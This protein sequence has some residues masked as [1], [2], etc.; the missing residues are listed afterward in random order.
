MAF[1]SVERDVVAQNPG[2][3]YSSLLESAYKE[4]AKRLE[5]QIDDEEAKAFG[6]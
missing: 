5:V 2:V 6:T 1:S 3:L 4:F